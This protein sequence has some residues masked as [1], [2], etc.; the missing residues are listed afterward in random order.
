M[1]G[2]RL[3]GFLVAAVGLIVLGG[4]GG[5][6]ACDSS[7]PG[8]VQIVNKNASEVGIT[9]NGGPDVVVPPA[10][11][12][13][14]GTAWIKVDTTVGA[15]AH[16]HAWTGIYSRDT[17]CIVK[18]STWA[19]PAKAPQVVARNYHVPLSSIDCGNW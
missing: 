18:A 3:V 7:T 2:I 1:N 5:D 14:P 16:F 10:S 6:T 12:V 13:Y 8:C 4:C 19:D 15:T 17:T 9:V 11:A